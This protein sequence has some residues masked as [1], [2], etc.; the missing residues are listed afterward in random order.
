MKVY[1]IGGGAKA[2]KNTF[3]KYLREE[4]K[5]YGHK[6]CVMRLTEPLYSYAHNYFDWDENT[7]EKPREFLQ[8]MGIE[9]IKEKLHKTYFLLDRL[10]E[11]IE[12]LSNFFDVFIIT[13]ARLIMEFEELKKRY[14]DVVLIKVER[15]DYDNG[16]SLEE[17][18]HITETELS[19]Y[20]GFNYKVVNTGFEDLARQAS[21]I[22]KNEERRGSSN[23]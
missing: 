4:A 21:I 9:I 10:S 13:D 17:K 11:D 19:D 2:G 18:N 5:R 16:L 23:E 15:D 3:G 20:R 22:V 1:V 6:P 12:I 7:A 14:D 8:K